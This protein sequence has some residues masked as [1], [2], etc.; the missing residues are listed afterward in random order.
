M[1]N[2][3]EQEPELPKE[4]EKPEPKKQ[5]FKRPEPKK[6]KCPLCESE[7]IEYQEAEITSTAGGK[8]RTE[9]KVIKTCLD[10]GWNSK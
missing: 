10:C 3:F 1:R 6:E 7:K 5:Q 2:R 8:L 4:I 9:K